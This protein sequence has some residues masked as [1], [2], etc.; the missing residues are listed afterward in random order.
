[1]QIND[2]KWPSFKNTFRLEVYWTDPFLITDQ[3]EY[4][5]IQ[6]SFWSPKAKNVKK[7]TN[8]KERNMGNHKRW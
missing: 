2:L 8:K 5:E 6:L 3:S 7:K 4:K 1:M